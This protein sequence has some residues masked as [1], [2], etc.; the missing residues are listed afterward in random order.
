[1]N[2]AART[3]YQALMDAGRG[4]AFDRHVFTCTL[5]LAAEE[6]RPFAQ[7]LGLPGQLLAGLLDAYYP[8]CRTLLPA[9]AD[10]ET[11]GEDGIEEPDLR[12]L[13]LDHRS[14]SGPEG[15]WLAHIVA[16]RSLRPDHLWQDLGLHSRADLSGLLRRHFEPL[17]SRNVH[18]LKWKKF[19]YREL[20]A[21]EGFVVCKAPSCAACSDIQHC[22]GGA[23]GDPLARFQD[24]PPPG[25]AP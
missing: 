24:P 15:H 19:F 18:D 25:S 16:R 21:R 17:A 4:D 11:A 5:S 8:G 12:R 22:Y 13:L 2:L 1:V 23:D 7:A 14:S 3:L 10:T 9:F 6:D 20:C